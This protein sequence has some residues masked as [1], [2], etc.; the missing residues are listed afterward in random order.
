MSPA[1]TASVTWTPGAGASLGPWF[2]T[3]MV[4]VVA[5]PATTLATPSVFVTTSSVRGA[6]TLTCAVAALLPGAGSAVALVA[7]TVF[8]IGSGAV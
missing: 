3:V 8:T 2:C 6:L 5:V 1:G 7:V 4:Y